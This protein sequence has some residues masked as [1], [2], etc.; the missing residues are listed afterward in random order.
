MNL[1][2]KKL[3]WF[4]LL[5]IC[6]SLGTF[7]MFIS[8]VNV[9]NTS[10]QNIFEK[11]MPQETPLEETR[12]EAILEREDGSFLSITDLAPHILFENPQG[13]RLLFKNEEYTIQYNHNSNSFLISFL[14]FPTPTLRKEAE[15]NLMSILMVSNTKLCELPIMEYVSKEVEDGF[16]AGKDYGVSLCP[17]T[18]PLE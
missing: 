17:N 4:F 9:K 10:L 12:S 7:Y 6:V 15:K 18:T 5:G 1:F 13:D 8:L 2:T 16:Y 11:S 3:F 14:V